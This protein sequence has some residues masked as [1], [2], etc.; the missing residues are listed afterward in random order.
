LNDGAD[1]SVKRLPLACSLSEP[2]QARRRGELEENCEG[3]L[4]TTDL[5]DGYVFLPGSD[6]RAFKLTEFI[7]FERACC[8]FFTF[9][10]VFELGGGLTRLRVRGPAGT[11]GIVAEM[12]T[13][14]TG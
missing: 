8:P 11:K 14:R 4:R 12:F 5:E 3:C 2:A 10:L 1:Q 7:D 9:G 13:S 6:E